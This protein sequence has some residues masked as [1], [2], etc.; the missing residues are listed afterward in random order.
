VQTGAIDASSVGPPAA[1]TRVIYFDYDVTSSNLNFKVPLK[2][3]HLAANK[4][5]KSSAIE[6]NTVTNAAVVNT[7]WRLVKSVLKQY[8][9]DLVWVL[10]MHRWRQ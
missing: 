2:R 5:R 6:G 1:V 7:I 8:G 10:Q 4:S 3:W 9:V